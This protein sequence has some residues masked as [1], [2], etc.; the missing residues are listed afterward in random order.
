MREVKYREKVEKGL[1]Q[2]KKK[3]YVYTDLLTFLTPGKKIK[4]QR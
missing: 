2:P 1:A 4:I 3:K